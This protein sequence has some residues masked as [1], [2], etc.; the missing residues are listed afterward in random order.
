[1][2]IQLDAIIN[3]MREHRDFLA[4]RAMQLAAELAVEKEAVARLQAERDQAAL[5]SRPMP[6]ERESQ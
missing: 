5:Q 6:A 2:Q 3:E 1:M 4:A